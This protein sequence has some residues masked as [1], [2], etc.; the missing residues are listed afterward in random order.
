MEN[1]IEIKEAVL[2]AVKQ[3]FIVTVPG[4]FDPRNFHHNGSA[5]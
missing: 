4:H 2:I 1:L 3:T 5:F